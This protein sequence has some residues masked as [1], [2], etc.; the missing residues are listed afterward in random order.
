MGKDIAHVVQSCEECDRVNTS[1]NVQAKELQPLP[2]EGLFYGWGVDLAGPFNPTS[3]RGNRYVFVAIEHFSKHITVVPIPDKSAATTSR[4]FTEYV[5]CR[6]GS[7]AEVMTDVGPEFAGESAELLRQYCIDHRTTPP[8]HPQADGL[9]ERAVQTIKRALKKV[10]EQSQKPEE[11]DMTL[12]WIAFGYNCSVQDS[13]KFSPYH[14]LY[15]RAPVVPPAQMER[16]ATPL[17]LDDPELACD[18]VLERGRIA[19]QAS[20]IAGSNPLI[21]QHRDKL[22]YAAIRGGGYLPVLREFQA[23][24][25]MYLKWRN[26]DSVL[27]MAAKRPVYRVKDVRENG[28]IILQGK[29]GTTF[30]NHV[31]N[32]APCIYL[33]FIQ[34]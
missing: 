4:I 30:V 18:H 19:H 3:N 22:R 31:V 28:T 15:A 5:L 13:T 1:F 34:P 9:A 2:V 26:I 7:C 16:Y 27:Q 8:N 17:N 11:W 24:D 25:F 23:G 21:A 32:C 33:A 29:C 10:C 20:I 14:L 6:F 12:P